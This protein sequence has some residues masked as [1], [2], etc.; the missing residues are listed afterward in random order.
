MEEIA[1]KMTEATSA[2]LL[3]CIG[4]IVFG[5]GYW[6]IAT[7][8]VATSGNKDAIIEVARH[9]LW[10]KIFHGRSLTTEEVNKRIIPGIWTIYRYFGRIGQIIGVF[11]MVIGAG[12]SIIILISLLIKRLA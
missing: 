8:I 10:T 1:Q 9:N 6:M 11:V 3:K 7:M 2:D 12:M 4:V 5:L